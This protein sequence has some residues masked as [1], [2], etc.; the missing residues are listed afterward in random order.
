MDT[1]TVVLICIAIFII[2]MLLCFK[3]KKLLVKLIPAVLLAA[4]FVIFLLLTVTASGW[5]S[6]AYIVFVMLS[7]AKRVETRHIKHYGKIAEYNEYAD[8]TPLLFPL[9]PI[10]HVTN[11]EKIA[12]EEAAKKAKA[13]KRSK[14]S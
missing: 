1:L 9:I 10:Y 8:K 3:A 11:E 2:Q 5:D 4:S 6:L 14:N 13:E 12:A 7:G